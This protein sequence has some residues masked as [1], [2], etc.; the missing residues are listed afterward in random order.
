MIVCDKNW[1]EELRVRVLMSLFASG[2][3]IGRRGSLSRQRE[4]HEHRHRGR[5][6][7]KAL[8]VSVSVSKPYNPTGL[9]VWSLPSTYQSSPHVHTEI[10]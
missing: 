3:P 6:T 7:V 1:T 4:Q 9:S 2:K 10:G 8:S 5:R